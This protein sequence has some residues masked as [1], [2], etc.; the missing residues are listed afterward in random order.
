MADV[1]SHSLAWQRANPGVVTPRSTA[2]VAS[3][4]NV[5]AGGSV[6]KPMPTCLRVVHLNHLWCR[7]ALI[8][9]PTDASG[10]T[11]W[12]PRALMGASFES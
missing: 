6:R 4:L 7:G 1:P 10:P 3:I 9:K 11:N 5:G 2:V 8:G 12:S